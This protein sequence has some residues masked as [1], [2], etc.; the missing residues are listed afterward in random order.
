MRLLLL[1][2]TF[3]FEAFLVPAQSD[4]RKIDFKN[5]TYRLRCGDVDSVSPVTVR[6]GEY[7]GYKAGLGGADLNFPREVQ[8]VFLNVYEVVYGDIDGDKVDEA[9]VLYAC[10]SGAS[11]VYF[12]GLIFRYSNKKASFVTALEGGNK[13][14]GGFHDVR[15]V[16]GALVVERYQM[17]IAGVGPETIVT[18]KYKLKAKRLIQLGTP[19]ERNIDP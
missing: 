15:V 10:G 7:S 14:D 8:N 13:G 9:I 2:L 12:R 11:Y 19:K 18:T 3:F 5:F 6:N 1:I 16:K 4:I 17:G